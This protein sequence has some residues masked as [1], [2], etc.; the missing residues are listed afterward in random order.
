MHAASGCNQ[1]FGIQTVMPVKAYKKIAVS[2]AQESEGPDGLPVEV[3][4]DVHP[5]RSNRA[6]DHPNSLIQ[7]RG[8]CT[9][10]G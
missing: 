6:V 3:E 5:C 10:S 9:D 8:W 2:T 7:G 1:R 4:I